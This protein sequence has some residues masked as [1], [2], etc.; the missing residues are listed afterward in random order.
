MVIK[1]FSAS[2]DEEIVL[3][4]QKM[5]KKY[6]S[7]FS[8]LINHLLTTWVNEEERKEKELNIKNKTERT[9]T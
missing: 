6:G 4:T 2:L 9:N 5:M 1:I 3:R 7:K 8:P